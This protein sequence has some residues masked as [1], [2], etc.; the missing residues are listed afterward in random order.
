L[1]NLVNKFLQHFKDIHIRQLLDTKNIL[2]YTRYIDDILI[3]YDTT[4]THP[5]AINAH[6]NHIHDNI[7]LNPTYENNMCINVLDLTITRKQTSETK[8]TANQLSPTQK[9]TSSQTP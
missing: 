8:Y 5:H 7:N 1:Y 6:I 3:I 9:S 2:L 4:R